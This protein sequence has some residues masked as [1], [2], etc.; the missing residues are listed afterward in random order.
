MSEVRNGNRPEMDRVEALVERLCSSWDLVA[1]R[2]AEEWLDELTDSFGVIGYW[3]P[4]NGDTVTFSVAD[5]EIEEEVAACSKNA[6]TDVVNWARQEFFYQLDEKEFLE[7][8]ELAYSNR[9]SLERV[10]TAAGIRF[11]GTITRGCLRVHLDVER[12]TQIVCIAP[13]NAVWE[14]RLDRTSGPMWESPDGEP[15]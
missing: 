10:T 6:L 8:K 11:C 2:S 15:K 14:T 3:S 12:E 7:L 1:T 4:S 9:V 5:L 13:L